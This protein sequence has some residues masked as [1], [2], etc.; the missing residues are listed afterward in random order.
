MTFPRNHRTKLRT[1]L[2]STDATAHTEVE[3]KRGTA[4]MRI[5]SNQVAIPRPAGAIPMAQNDDWAMRRSRYMTQAH[6]RGQR[7]QRASFG[8]P[9]QLTADATPPGNTSKTHGS[10]APS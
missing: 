4:V 1:K 7:R 6:E 10:H 5:L 9:R 2:S 8:R 3:I